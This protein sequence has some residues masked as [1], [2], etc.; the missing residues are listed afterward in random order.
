MTKRVVTLAHYYTQPEIQ[1]MADKVGDSLELSLYAREAE[2]D[3]IVFAGVRFMAE[4]A[5]ILNPQA[6]VIL[7]DAGSTCSLVTRAES[8]ARRTRRLR[9]RVVHQL[10]RRAQGPVGLDRHQ[11]Q[12]R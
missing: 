12:R 8:L 6:E 9:P 1:Q 3:T 4:T 2:A 7:P 10:Q 5:K 11:P